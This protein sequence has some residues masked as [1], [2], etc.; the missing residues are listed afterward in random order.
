MGD[1]FDRFQSPDRGRFGDN[2]SAFSQSPTKQARSNLCDVDVVLH[3]DK[4]EKKAIAVSLRQDTPFA[5]WIW[6][7]RSLIEYE[8]TGLK[9][10]RVTLPESLAKEKGLL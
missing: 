6:L 5:Q 1:T 2:E 4:P 7:P 9:H 8:L 3:H 10:C